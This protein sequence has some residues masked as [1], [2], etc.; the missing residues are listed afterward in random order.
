MVWE[1]QR[2]IERQSARQRDRE[3][4]RQRERYR[5]RDIHRQTDRQTDRPTNR[6][7]QAYRRSDTRGWAR[8]VL[9]YNLLPD[10]RIDVQSMHAGQQPIGGEKWSAPSRNLLPQKLPALSFP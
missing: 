4:E 10:G 2:E 3:A 8:Q 5:E 9:F 1:W 6:D 7:R